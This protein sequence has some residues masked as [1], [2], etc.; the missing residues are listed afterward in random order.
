MRKNVQSSCTAFLGLSATPSPWAV[1]RSGLSVKTA[2][3]FGPRL[4]Q[5]VHVILD[6]P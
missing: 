4:Q 5:A 2:L 3:Q 1:T 6:L